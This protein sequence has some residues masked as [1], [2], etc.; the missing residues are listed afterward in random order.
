MCLDILGSLNI[1]KVLINTLPIFLTKI[2]TFEI[3]KFI[4]EMKK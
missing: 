4:K 3:L 1:R 2:F